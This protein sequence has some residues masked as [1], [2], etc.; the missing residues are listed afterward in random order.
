ML[1]NAMIP[2]LAYTRLSYEDFE[3]S[4]D[5]SNGSTD[6]AHFSERSRLILLRIQMFKDALNAY[7]KLFLQHHPALVRDPTTGAPLDLEKGV[8]EVRDLLEHGLRLQVMLC[9]LGES[10]TN[11]MCRLGF[12]HL[13]PVDNPVDWYEWAQW[14]R[15]AEIGHTPFA[16]IAVRID[17]EVERIRQFAEADALTDYE[18]LPDDLFIVTD[19]RYETTLGTA[20][21]RRQTSNLAPTPEKH[22]GVQPTAP[23]RGDVGMRGNTS[24]SNA[25]D[26]F[27]KHSTIWSNLSTA[28]SFLEK[29]GLSIWH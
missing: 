23:S 11:R 2:G 20:P 26:A 14:I 1:P 27:V 12:K 8:W 19:T 3:M 18:R 5:S 9:A 17:S 13:V 21:Y 16:S 6:T 7:F 28:L 15:K 4:L 29:I 25:L 10:A 22:E 24:P